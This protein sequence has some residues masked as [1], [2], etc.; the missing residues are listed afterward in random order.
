M[1]YPTTTHSHYH[2]S[3]PHTHVHFILARG[4]E[5]CAHP[6]C[7]SVQK[8]WESTSRRWIPGDSCTDGT[9]LELTKLQPDAVATAQ[10][11]D[12]AV[13]VP[14]LLTSMTSQMSKSR[15]SRVVGESPEH[16]SDPSALLEQLR[17]IKA[18]GQPYV[19]RRFDPGTQLKLIQST[20][21]KC[22]LE[23]V[24]DLLA[25][26]GGME[27]LHEALCGQN[28]TLK[29]A[30]GWLVKEFKGVAEF[31]A[32]KLGGA[33]QFGGLLL[34]SDD[35]PR[36]GRKEGCSTSIRCLVHAYVSGNP[37]FP[38]WLKND[39]LDE[40][41]VNYVTQFDLM[42]IL[43][44]YQATWAPRAQS[45]WSERKAGD[46]SLVRWDH[47]VS[48]G[49]VPT[50]TIL[51]C[52]ARFCEVGCRLLR[53][54]AF[55]DDSEVDYPKGEFKW[56]GRQKDLSNVVTLHVGGDGKVHRS[57]VDLRPRE[58]THGVGFGA[59][60]AVANGPGGLAPTEEM[61]VEQEDEM[62]EMEEEP[63]GGGGGDVTID[64]LRANL[65]SRGLSINEPFP[66]ILIVSNFAQV[67]L[68]VPS[69]ETL[70]ASLH[71]RIECR[72]QGDAIRDFELQ[73]VGGD[74]EALHY[75]G[76]PIHR[77][78]IWLQD[79]DPNQGVRVYSYTGWQAPVAF[80]TSDW[81]GDD[82]LG[83]ICDGFN[84]FLDGTDFNPA[85]HAIVTAY[86]DQT[87]GIGFHYDKT[88]TLD[89]NG[90]IS[91][92]KLGEARRFEV[93]TRL[94]PLDTDGMSETECT[95]A[96]AAHAKAQEAVQPLFSETLQAGTLV[97]MTNSANLAT[98]HAVPMMQ[99]PVGLSGSIVFRSITRIDQASDL[100]RK[101]DNVLASRQKK[102]AQREARAASGTE[103]MGSG[104]DEGM[105]VEPAEVATSVSTLMPSTTVTVGEEVPR[106]ASEKEVFAMEICKYPS[107]GDD[108]VAA[109]QLLSISKIA[110]NSTSPTSD[111][112]RAHGV[113]IKMVHPDRFPGNAT[114]AN[115]A[116]GLVNAAKELLLQPRSSGGGSSSAPAPSP[117]PSAPTPAPAPAPDPA[118]SPEP[119]ATGACLK[120]LKLQIHPVTQVLTMLFS[121]LFV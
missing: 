19:R 102:L 11:A 23:Q 65:L 112:E 97:L 2:P 82:Q 109:C 121:T 6:D 40:M 14:K 4:I 81:H 111:V 17:T 83:G 86:D 35:C 12:V 41:G 51:G 37:D 93:R 42:R 34:G 92:V 94:P 60:A 100:R 74:N 64:K 13:V 105:E 98:Q 116:A 27:R 55:T 48:V 53:A 79:G 25:S 15:V 21:S 24:S 80:A 120:I 118:S 9:T 76:N 43:R 50:P 108:R 113:L 3:C 114:L 16:F 28:S 31:V 78:K 49:F 10:E 8:F 30:C 57:Q 20:N 106:A 7:S 39:K 62:I 89:P 18:T 63:V 104:E 90:V 95:K 72:R 87:Y 103:P 1:G 99:D 119:A 67:V 77:R 101:R 56:D 71:E 54:I 32:L 85:N 88:H 68:G 91:V 46:A 38:T 26:D 96:K 44:K 107:A 117:V 73:F 75:R 36:I 33:L 22:I 70:V 84:A 115:S 110:I 69:P 47:A 58:V 29:T 59:V 5:S 45:V 52:E 61:E 66:G